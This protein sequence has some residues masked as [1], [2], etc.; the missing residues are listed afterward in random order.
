MERRAG[1]WTKLLPLELDSTS[2]CIAEVS[3]DMESIYLDR[4]F[5]TSDI[6]RSLLP[7][8]FYLWSRRT[9]FSRF[10]TY[11][12]THRALLFARKTIPKLSSLFS[13]RELYG[14]TQRSRYDEETEGFTRYISICRGSELNRRSLKINASSVCKPTSEQIFAVPDDSLTIKDP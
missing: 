1:D 9:W 5:P 2:E 10:T 6:F 7:H 12:E 14:C 11:C 3:T 8:F 13:S 4:L